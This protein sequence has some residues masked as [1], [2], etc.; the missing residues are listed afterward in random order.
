MDTT[1]PHQVLF[2]TIW[3][4]LGQ[5]ARDMRCNCSSVIWVD[6]GVLV[7]LPL[8]VYLLGRVWRVG[9]FRTYSAV[10]LCR[11]WLRPQLSYDQAAFAL[12]LSVVWAIVYWPVKRKLE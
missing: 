8:C 6:L 12:F 7:G 3:L 10:A 9:L 11:V 2:S 1:L 5:Y 4:A